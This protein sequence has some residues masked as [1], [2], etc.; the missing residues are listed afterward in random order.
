MKISSKSKNVKLY[1]NRIS[2]RPKRVSS[3][4][5]DYGNRFHSVKGKIKMAPSKLETAK[6]EVRSK[7]KKTPLNSKLGK[8]KRL[9]HSTRR[10]IENDGMTVQQGNRT[11]T[12]EQRVKNKASAKIR[13]ARYTRDTP[14]KSKM[15]AHRLGR[16]NDDDLR[17]A[18]AV[19]LRMKR[20]RTK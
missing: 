11:I 6:K 18:K 1:L 9:I 7:Y 4:I 3:G 8:A 20:L 5:D 2:G 19:E 16:L 17:G 13:N 10:K 12:P 14:V 15:K